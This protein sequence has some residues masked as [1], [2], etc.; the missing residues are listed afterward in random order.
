MLAAAGLLAVSL[1]ANAGEAPT[2]PQSVAER[3]DWVPVDALSSA[4]R[5]ALA[6][7]C[8]GA[9]VDSSRTP[10]DV[11]EEAT[12]SGQTRFTAEEG[13]TRNQD[14]S[15]HVSGEVSIA[16]NGRSIVNDGETLI[17]TA[18]DTFALE[19]DIEF[20]E[21]G[22][23]LRGNSAFIDNRNNRS[24]L[25]A[26]RY[27][28]HESGIH[29][30][31][32]TMVYD[33]ESGRI[34]LDDGE[35]SRC[36]PVDP[37]W[38]IAARAITLEPAQGQGNARD[39]RLRFGETTVFRYPFALR[40]PLGDQRVSGLLPPSMGSTRSGGFDF[41]QPYYLNLA[42]HYDATLAPRLISDRGL[43]LGGEFRYLADWSMNQLNLSWLGG[44]DLFD[45]ERAAVPGS[46]SPPVE[47]RWFASY[48]HNGR[49]GEHW[50][51]LVDLLPAARRF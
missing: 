38:T 37:F 7:A 15:I 31:A 19:G 41:E 9:F 24:E 6:P 10:A 16:E 18:A 44:D 43:M 29:G 26:A 45:A 39:L 32:A 50:R 30:S 25:L 2:G 1:R 48:Q 47:N 27:V 49:I 33:S 3:L 21:P 11:A 23:L 20:R 35:F 22:V 46:Q 14:D 5:E 36:E 12:A 8:C 13:F 17:D 42:P 28:L 40:F 34:T 51:T 4:R